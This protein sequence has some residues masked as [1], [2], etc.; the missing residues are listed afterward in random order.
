MDL[1]VSVNG[2]RWGTVRTGITSSCSLWTEYRPVPSFAPLFSGKLGTRLRGTSEK[3]ATGESWREAEQ[4]RSDMVMESS[5]TECDMAGE[6]RLA[7]GEGGGAKLE[8]PGFTVCVDSRRS[9][10]LSELVLRGD[11]SAGR[12]SGSIRGERC[13]FAWDVVG[14]RLEWWGETYR[15]GWGRSAEASISSSLT[16]QYDICSASG[17]EL[18]EARKPPL[19]SL[20]S[21]EERL[22]IVGVVYLGCV[23]ERVGSVCLWVSGP[24]PALVIQGLK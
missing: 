22:R 12:L 8:L 15:R 18:A 24:V 23:A 16:T 2:R 17:A 21:A 6:D 19:G 5:G 3:E 1:P 11:G 10:W 20:G 9:A 4:L 7:D 14:E 13:G